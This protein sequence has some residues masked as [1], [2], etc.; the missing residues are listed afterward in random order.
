MATNMS[1]YPRELTAVEVS[2]GLDVLVRE[3]AGRLLDGPTTEHRAL[4]GQ[5]AVARIERVT[6][7]GAGLYAYFAHPVGTRPVSPPEMIG[8][9]VPMELPELDAPAGSLL[10]V[11]G[12]RLDYVEVYTFGDRPWP[13]EPQGVSFG[14]ATPLA[15]PMEAI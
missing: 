6:L 8:G 12:G 3:L 11:S 2:P 7:T 10:K 1:N 14:E 4:R 9:E 5:L 13:D 15:V